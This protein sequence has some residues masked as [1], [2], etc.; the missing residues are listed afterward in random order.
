MGDKIENKIE[1]L[2]MKSISIERFTRLI[3]E[4]IEDE[5]YTP[6]LGLGLSGIGKTESPVELCREMGIGCKEMRLVTLTEVD[7]LGVPIVTP[8]G[9]TDYASNNL[10]PDAK[11][12]GRKRHT[13]SR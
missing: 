12:D 9:R 2:G 5:D 4:Q 8:E 7:M 1:T 3:K 6:I 11:S 10:L 13:D